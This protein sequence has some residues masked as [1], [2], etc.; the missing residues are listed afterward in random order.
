MRA[1]LVAGVSLFTIACGGTTGSGLVT[2]SGVASG[3]SD[4]SDGS[5][6]FT[7]GAGAD[8]TLTKA[9]M[10]LGAVYL[11]QSVPSSGAAAEPCISPGIYVAE[12]FGPLDVDLL[13]GS[14]V[15]FPTTGEGTE[16]EAKTAEV[17]LTNGDVNA[18]ED[19]TVIFDVE[20]T[21]VQAG[22]TYPFR[23]S[24][25]IGSNR[26]PKVTNAALPSAN[27]VCHKRIVSPI[28][29]DIT[30]TAGGALVLEIDPRHMFNGVDF[31][32]ATKVSDAPVA[33]QIPDTSAGPGGALFKGMTSNAGVYAFSW[34]SG[35]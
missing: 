4:V 35:R 22:Q 27:P 8:I 1:I 16:T 15:H 3:P 7:S 5:V 13:S 19:P 31:S 29:V 25:T 26:T 10:H 2:F 30:P 9:Q 17:W 6:S 32:Q 11:N 23:A 18:K 33:Y 21:A 14:P 34:K 12:V 20:G 28:L 24:I